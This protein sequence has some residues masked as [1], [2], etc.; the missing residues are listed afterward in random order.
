MSLSL[1][2]I[3]ASALVSAAVYFVA[4]FVQR[5]RFYKDLVRLNPHASPLN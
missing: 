5:R 1:G 2:S 4:I 3:L